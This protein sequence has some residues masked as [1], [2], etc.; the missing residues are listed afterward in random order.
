MGVSYLSIR[1]PGRKKKEGEGSEEK[2][3]AD[4]YQLKSCILCQST[5]LLSS[6]EVIF[7]KGDEDFTYKE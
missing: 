2:V 1:V 7:G 4:D 3:S 6:V 5:E